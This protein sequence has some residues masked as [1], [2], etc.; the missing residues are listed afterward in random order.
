[1]LGDLSPAL[2]SEILLKTLS[3]WVHSSTRNVE[4]LWT[5]LGMLLGKSANSRGPSR[6]CWQG[7]MNCRAHCPVRGLL[8]KGPWVGLTSVCSQLTEWVACRASAQRRGYCFLIYLSRGET[9]HTRNMYILA[10]LRGLKMICRSFYKKAVFFE[11]VQVCLTLPFPQSIPS[12]ILGY[13]WELS[14]FCLRPFFL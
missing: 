2:A 10:I 13:F 9:F 7:T 6:L 1:M 12:Q 11:F 8:V 5:L 4:L 14:G 3:K